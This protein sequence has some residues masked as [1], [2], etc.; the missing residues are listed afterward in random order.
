VFFTRPG[1]GHEWFTFGWEDGETEEA[2]VIPCGDTG[3]HAASSDCKCEPWMDT[4]GS[5]VHRAFDGRC[6]YED[7]GRMPS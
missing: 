7:K 5:W 1:F 6:D 3:G 2:H 4:D